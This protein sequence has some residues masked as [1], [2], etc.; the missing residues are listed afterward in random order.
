MSVYDVGCIILVYSSNILY[1]ISSDF[2]NFVICFL[3]R[4][5]FG[6]NSV[7]ISELRICKDNSREH[8]REQYV[9]RGH[10]DILASKNHTRKISKILYYTKSS[11]II[12][13]AEMSRYPH[14]TYCLQ[15]ESTHFALR[16][17]TYF[18]ME[19]SRQFVVENHI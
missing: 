19:V 14:Y 6:I 11:Y 3:R 17:S 18:G 13:Y 5:G 4:I 1:H 16:V 15:E 12:F 8:L 9:S 2:K 10:R 7:A